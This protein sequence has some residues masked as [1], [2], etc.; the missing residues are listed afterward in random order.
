M[1]GVATRRRTGDGAG[2]PAPSTLPFIR[3]V[4]LARDAALRLLTIRERSSAEIRRSLD[5]RGFC[6]DAVSEVLGSLERS[7]LVNDQ[8]FAERFTED[9]GHARGWSGA[10]TRGELARRGIAR[11]LAVEATAEPAGDEMERAIAVA[12]AR[13]Q[14]MRSLS[15][16]ARF[17]RVVAYLARRGYSAEICRKAATAATRVL[18]RDFTADVG[19]SRSTDDDSAN[20]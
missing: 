9:V 1:G 18:D 4:T 11:E 7:G 13:A 2:K 12:R 5:R 6:E 19:F 14:R 16:D 20:P 17:R 3:Q 15:A 10:R 8:R